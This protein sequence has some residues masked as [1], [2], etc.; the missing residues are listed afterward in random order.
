MMTMAEEQLNTQGGNIR[1]SDDVVATIAGLTALK[2]PG[3][4]AMS[5]IKR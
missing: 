5:T 2:T 3:I 4:A 1:I